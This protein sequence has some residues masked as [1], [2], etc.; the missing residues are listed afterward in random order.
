MITLSQAIVREENLIA[1][2]NKEL[3]KPDLMK[4]QIVRYSLVKELHKDYL[5][6]LTELEERRN[7]D[8]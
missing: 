4:W 1:N 3:D 2:C 5:G 7:K 8:V 6:F